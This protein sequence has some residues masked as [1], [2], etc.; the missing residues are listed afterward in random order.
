M[1]RLYH[2]H[3]PHQ[4]VRTERPHPAAALLLILALAILAVFW[5]E[6]PPVASLLPTQPPG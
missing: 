4:R 1:A 6:F 2:L 5:R 3:V